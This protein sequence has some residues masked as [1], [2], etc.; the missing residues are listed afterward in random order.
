LAAQAALGKTPDLGEA[1][2]QVLE[3]L[4]DRALLAQAAAEDGFQVDDS[5]LQA[6]IE[7]LAA[8]IGGA[9][10]L[11]DWQAAHGYSEISFRS[12]LRLELSAA[13]QR[14]QVIGQVPAA[15]DQVHVRQILV[16]SQEGAAKVLTQVQSGTEF[17]TLAFKY[18]PVSGGDLG[19]FPQGYLDIAEIE[20][21]AFALQ[22]D[23]TSGI[24]QSKVGYHVIQVVERDPER[25]LNSDQ[26]LV[27]QKKVL[28]GWL[29]AR[30]A[31]SQI[32]VMIQ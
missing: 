4:V 19:W 30:R 11:K 6:R 27:L 22:P 24:I 26:R 12:D 23:Q 16:P 25:P 28:R 31:S 5:A 18:D 29:D 15:A 1:R 2:K 32:V 20:T 7:H 21:A 9:Q 8:Q 13:W 3:D 10:A 17:A 14:D